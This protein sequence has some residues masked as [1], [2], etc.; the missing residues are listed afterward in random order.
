MAMHTH[1]L[2]VV[3]TGTAA[4]VTAMGCRK[5]GWS[6]AVVDHRPFGGTCALRG[7]DPKTLETQ[8]HQTTQSHPAWANARIKPSRVVASA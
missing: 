2:I 4:N 5:G 3:G 7:C 1:D 6:V 8:S